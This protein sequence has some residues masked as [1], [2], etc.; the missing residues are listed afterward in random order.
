MFTMQMYLTCFIINVERIFNFIYQDEYPFTAK[1]DA[2]ITENHNK[3]KV[4][5]L[6]T[7]YR[8]ADFEMDGFKKGLKIIAF[9]DDIHSLFLEYHIFIVKGIQQRQMNSFAK[10]FIILLEKESIGDGLGSKSLNVPYG[11]QIQRHINERIPL[12]IHLKNATKVKAK[13][14]W[15]QV[16]YHSYVLNFRNSKPHQISDIQVGAEYNTSNIECAHGTYDVS[17]NYDVSNVSSKETCQLDVE[18]IAVC[19]T[20]NVYIL[21]TGA[22]MHFT[23]D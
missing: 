10:Q 12:Y 1:V 20:A 8:E 2:D 21:A 7:M 6:T 5:V 9:S 23:Y 16:M 13:K 19:D 18:R 15:S 11:M 4:Y 17:Y 22:D 14:R 3:P